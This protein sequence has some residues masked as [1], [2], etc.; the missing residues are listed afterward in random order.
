MLDAGVGREMCTFYIQASL[1]SLSETKGY[2]KRSF[3][4]KRHSS[5]KHAQWSAGKHYHFIL[6]RLRGRV[7]KV[8]SSYA[9]SCHGKSSSRKPRGLFSHVL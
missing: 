9:N 8:N 6:L 1:V 3:L 7:W 2:F 5:R 4:R